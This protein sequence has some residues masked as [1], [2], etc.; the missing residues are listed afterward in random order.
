MVIAKTSLNSFYKP[1]DKKTGVYNTTMRSGHKKSSKLILIIGIMGVV[2][3]V[4]VLLCIK[5]TQHFPP[6]TNSDLSI[7]SA[8]ISIAACIPIVVVTG[9]IIKFINKYQ[10]DDT[11]T[12][13]YQQ[14]NTA[15]DNNVVKAPVIKQSAFEQSAFG[16]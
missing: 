8:F 1:L 3:S 16:D 10:S 6:G 11:S 7:K 13:S 2:L 4:A 9:T 14:L 5:F 12:D 15:L